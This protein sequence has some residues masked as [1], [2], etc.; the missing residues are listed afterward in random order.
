M[1]GATI[2]Y[3]PAHSIFLV[4]GNYSFSVSYQ[5]GAKAGGGEQFR[6]LPRRAGSGTESERSWS[7]S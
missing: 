6:K 7:T 4:S 2:T 3:D 5:A 1:A